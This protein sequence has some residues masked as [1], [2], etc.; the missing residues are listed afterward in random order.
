MCIALCIYFG[1]C[2]VIA[3]FSLC[4][5][6]DGIFTGLLM[7]FFLMLKELSEDPDEFWKNR[8]Q[9]IGFILSAAGMMLF[10]KNAVY[11]FIV[12]IPF[13]I[14]NLKKYI[15]KTLLSTVIAVIIFGIISGGLITVL[16]AD[17]TENQEILTVPIMQIARV[18]YFDKDRLSQEE[19][20][21][22]YHF[23][24]EDTLKKYN[25]K[26]SDP[27]KIGFQ[28]EYYSK[29]KAEIFQ[30]WFSLL[31]K[32]PAT[33]LNAWFMTSYGFWYPDTV[34]DVYKGNQVFTFQYQDS[35]YFGYE[36]EQPG[37]RDSKIPW[38]DNIYK[39]ISLEIYQQKV[40]VISMLFSP[41]F[42]F[43]ILQM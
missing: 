27:V 19:L 18:H 6:K 1:I 39:K 42:L 35:S 2:P 5:A 23:L 41:G 33:Y 26:L 36:V 25:P 8:W 30:L 28:N 17:K 15:K 9:V 3:M 37:Y 20:Q 29:N 14:L 24:S 43:M 32:Y 40:P 10:R 21:T 31:K 4:T 34:I 22:M 38:L 16:H 13:L 11:A 12:F 7:I